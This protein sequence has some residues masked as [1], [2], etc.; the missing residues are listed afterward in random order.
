MNKTQSDGIIAAHEPYLVTVNRT[1]IVLWNRRV[2]EPF[3]VSKEPH[4]QKMI[5]LAENLEVPGEY[6]HAGLFFRIHTI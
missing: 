5:I 4:I 1:A 6:S 2:L 3:S